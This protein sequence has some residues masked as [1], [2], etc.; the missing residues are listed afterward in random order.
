M[1]NKEILEEENDFQNISL[2]EWILI[3]KKAIKE[4]TKNEEKPQ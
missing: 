4:R 3:L 1:T 2:P